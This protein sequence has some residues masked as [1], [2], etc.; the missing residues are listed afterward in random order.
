MI[1]Q[2]CSQ[3]LIFRFKS[4]HSLC[5]LN[6]IDFLRYILRLKRDSYDSTTT[7]LRPFG[8]L[9]SE[10]ATA[11]QSLLRRTRLSGCCEKCT[12]QNGRG[13]D[14]TPI[15]V[16]ASRPATVVASIAA[17]LYGDGVD[18]HTLVETQSS[19]LTRVHSHNFFFFLLLRFCSFE[20]IDSCPIRLI[21]FF[22]R[23]I[24]V[25]A[26]SSTARSLP[27]F[28]HARVG[29]CRRLTPSDKHLCA[30]AT[31]AA[32]RVAHD[33]RPTRVARVPP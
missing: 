21:N 6:V 9:P 8:A 14:A 2:F 22:V 19:I 5:G 31:N 7:I 1:D 32:A 4:F 3:T 16:T 27:S 24:S 20:M 30:A 11:H 13:Q 10:V 18:L 29:P 12:T 15:V 25:V 33:R 17:P 28:A 23:F 26:S